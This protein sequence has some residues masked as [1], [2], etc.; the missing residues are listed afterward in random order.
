Y[1]SAREI[2]DVLADCEQQLKTHGTL[3][4]FS[5]IPGGNVQPRRIGRKWKRAAAAV[6]LLLAVAAG[7]YAGPYALRYAFD[8]GKVT[9][10]NDEEDKMLVRRDG[11]LVATLD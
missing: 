7:A 8:A 4:D 11:Q 9:L 6:V 3:K 10:T 1:Q 5:R 2:A